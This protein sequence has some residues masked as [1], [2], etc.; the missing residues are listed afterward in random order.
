MI[1]AHIHVAAELLPYLKNIR[2][3][4]N[5]DSPAEYA[6]LQSSGFSHISA[7][8]HPWKADVTH[9]TE[10]EQ[11]LREASI[12]GEIGLDSEW[13]SIDMELQRSVFRKQ[14]A[15]AAHLRK[16]VI[17]HTKGMEREILDTIRQ[18]PNR[19][20]VHWYD[21]DQ[22]LREYIDL[23]CWFTVGPETANP[24]VAHLARTVPIDRLLMESDGLEGLA[25]GL[26]IELTASDYPA[27]ME[28]HL[29]AIA[30]LRGTDTA[31]LLQQMQRN[32]DSFING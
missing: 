7:G 11:I 29:Q 5:A 32:L 9:W 10:M 25:W 30:R 27:A 22:W 20:L 28:R 8:I 1:D 6:F 14:L 21:C 3:I 24:N 19:Y 23:G 12:I 15:L 13:C 31:S 4:P 18:H 26:G 2:C 17:L 16:P